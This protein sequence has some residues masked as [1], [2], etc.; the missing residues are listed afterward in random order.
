MLEIWEYF[1]LLLYEAYAL[2]KRKYHW[3]KNMK[4]DSIILF[5]PRKNIF[6]LFAPLS[7]TLMK[8]KEG[9]RKER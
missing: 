2:T 7:F 5:R 3:A 4:A 9:G 8:I 1:S 6:E